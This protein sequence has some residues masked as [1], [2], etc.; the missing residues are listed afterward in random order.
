MKK[1]MDGGLDECKS[2]RMER[3]FG[4]LENNKSK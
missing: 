1:W 3:I 4:I 2:G